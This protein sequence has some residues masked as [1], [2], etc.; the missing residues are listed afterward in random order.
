MKIEKGMTTIQIRKIMKEFG[1]DSKDEITS[2][3]WSNNKYGYMIWF[4][5]NDWHGVRLD[6]ISFHAGTINF[7]E[8]DELVYELAFK[9]L[10]AWL[11]YK[12]E[13][14]VQVAYGNLDVDRIQT[15][16]YQE[17]LKN[18]GKLENIDYEI[19]FELINEKKYGG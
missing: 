4:Q 9:T 8:I 3:G 6:K 5:R 16:F 10:N 11:V 13:V 7:D 19:M 12:Y 2:R 14:P 15:Q 18:N 1:W 17:A